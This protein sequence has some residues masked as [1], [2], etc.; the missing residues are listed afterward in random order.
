MWVVIKN[1]CVKL[2]PG[3]LFSKGVVSFAI[4]QSGQQSARMDLTELEIGT[5]L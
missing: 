1:V 3:N 5:H 2:T 4:T